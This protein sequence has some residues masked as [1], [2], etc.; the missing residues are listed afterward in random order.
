MVWAG[1]LVFGIS[2]IVAVVVVGIILVGT[3]VVF[4]VAVVSRQSFF[5]L[6]TQ[7]LKT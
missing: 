5:L 6:L 1:Q 7:Y 2:V 3:I 4:V